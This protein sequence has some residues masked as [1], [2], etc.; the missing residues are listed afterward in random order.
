MGD[1]LNKA[2]D[3]MMKRFEEVNTF[4]IE[5]VAEQIMAIGELNPTSIN[6]IAIMTEMGTNINDITQRLAI[7]TN[8]SLVVK[9]PIPDP[10]PGTSTM[11]KSWV[12]TFPYL[13]MIAESL[14]GSFQSRVQKSI[15]QGGHCSIA[16]ILTRWP[17]H[18][19]LNE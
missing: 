9:L 19:G 13:R 18:S 14:R 17:A 5:K 15:L 1:N 2:I 16:R 3:Y 11:E 4:F 7:A 6:R 10:T 12:R 8:T